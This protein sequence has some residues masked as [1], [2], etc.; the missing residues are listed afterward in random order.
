MTRT[1]NAS[2]GPVVITTRDSVMRVSETLKALAIENAR[3]Q[4]DLK[5]ALLGRAI[6]LSAEDLDRIKLASKVSKQ[7]EALV[8]F[9]ERH[10]ERGGTISDSNLA[11]LREAAALDRLYQTWQ[12]LEREG[13]VFVVS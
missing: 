6:A 2:G 8:P 3:L 5:S 7:I 12:S 11:L 4:R 13:A 1:R 9:L 10:I